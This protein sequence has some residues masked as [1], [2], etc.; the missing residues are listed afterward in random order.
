[1]S[2]VFL[3]AVVFP[4]LAIASQTKLVLLGTGTPRQDPDRFG[5]ASAVV[6]NGAAY[7]IDCGPGV[8]RR[9]AAARANGVPELAPVNLK[10]VFVTHL[11]SDHTLGYP[12]L[13]L[14]PWVV[15]RKD[16][17][18]AYG[19]TGLENMTSHILAAYSEDIDIRIHGLEHGNST[20]YKV[21]VHEIKPGIVYKDENVTVTAFYV[22]HGTWKEAFGY[23]F[24]TADRTIVFSGDT[25][26]C[27]D[28]AVAAQD[29]DVLVHEVYEE[30]EAA[31]ENRPGGDE[32]TKYMRSFHTSAQELG[33][34]AAKCKPKLLVLYHVLRRQATDAQLIE[35][36]RKGGFLG[37][38]VVAKDLDV[39]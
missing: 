12:D 26:P 7:L 23:Q 1:M 6:V 31:P 32:W 25:C 16:P 4:C 15:G 27:E 20:G 33:A 3:C 39:Y 19:P 30:S 9:A 38:V 29:A 35:E 22:K 11:H 10:H 2:A 28:L 37:P 36:V 17:L 8:V 21:N 5:P 24:K 13:I 18:E 14:S 34:I